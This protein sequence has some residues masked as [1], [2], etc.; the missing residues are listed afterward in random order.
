MSVLIILAIEIAW[1]TLAVTGP[2]WQFILASIG[3]V[4]TPAVYLAYRDGC[5][6]LQRNIDFVLDTPACDEADAALD[7][8]RHK[9]QPS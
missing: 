7:P 9:E 1:L 3:F 4:L 5:D 6:Q 2:E 8:V